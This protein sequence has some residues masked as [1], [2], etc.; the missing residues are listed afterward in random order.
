MYL[1][2]NISTA[3]L[4]I[5]WQNWAVLTLS[6]HNMTVLHD[7]IYNVANSKCLQLGG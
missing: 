5:C 3:S 2:K 6:C 7:N 4:S 1:I